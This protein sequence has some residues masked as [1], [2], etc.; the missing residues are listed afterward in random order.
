MI[1]KRLKEYFPRTGGSPIGYIPT[2]IKWIIQLDSN[3]RYLGLVETSSGAIKGKDRG[4]V[5]YAP[6]LQ[7]ASGVKAKLL[8]QNRQYVLGIGKDGSRGGRSALCQEAFVDELQSCYKKTG[9]KQVETVLKFFKSGDARKIGVDEIDVSENIT[10]N[11]DGSMPMEQPDVTEYWAS[12]CSPETGDDAECLVCSRL[13]P[14]LIR[15]PMKIKGLGGQA[16]GTSL[17]SANE[18]AFESFGLE[19]SLI[20]PICYE[21]AEESHKALNSLIGDE[22]T[23]LRIG[24]LTYVFWTRKEVKFSISNFLNDPNPDEVKALLRSPFAGKEIDKGIDDTG[25]YAVALVGSGGRAVIRDWLETTIGNVKRN[26]ARYFSF[27]RVYS[28]RD[29]GYTPL[30]LWRI[31]DATVPI[32]GGRADRDKMA[33]NVPKILLRFALHGGKLPMFLLQQA[34]ARCRAEQAVSQPRAVLIKMVLLSNEDKFEED[35]MAELNPGERDPAY[36]CGRLLRTLGAIQDYAIRPTATIIDRYYGGASS[37]PVT[38]FPNL[39]RGAQS[40]LSKLRK[41]PAKKGYSVMAEKKLGEIMAGLDGFPKTLTLE[42]QGM[43][44]LGYYH[45]RQADFT[46]RDDRNSEK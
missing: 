13:R 21:C 32:R 16:S 40:H 25:F 4:K 18:K 23:R 30:P 39:L 15:L 12:K 3:G 44:A 28:S 42:Q 17:V 10:F 41:D 35:Y 11:V 5:F 29:A 46:K 43:F 1:L 33:P 45:Q 24:T 6:H 27:Q 22:Q 34:V 19:N 36:L 8:A 20:A 9:N 37:S 31:T 38:V 2:N 26:L 7:I 14:P